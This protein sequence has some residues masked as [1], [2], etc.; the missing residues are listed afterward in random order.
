MV[1]PVSPTSRTAARA[2]TRE[3]ERCVRHDNHGSM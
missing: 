1:R 2:P 3:E